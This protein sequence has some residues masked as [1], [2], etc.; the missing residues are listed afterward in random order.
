MAQ[1]AETNIVPV[2]DQAMLRS[3]VSEAATSRVPVVI[4]FENDITLTGTALTILRDANVTLTSD[5]ALASASGVEFFRLL[6]VVGANTILVDGGGILKLDGIIVTHASGNGRGVEVSFS[7][8]LELCSGVISGNTLSGNGAGVLN[9]GTFRMYGGMIS[10]N[11]AN[12]GGGVYNSDGTFILDAGVISNN[13]ASSYGAGVYSTGI[14]SMRGGEISSNTITHYYSGGGVYNS[15]NFVLESGAI[16]RNYAVL[17][18]GVCSTSAFTMSGG[19]ISDNTVYSDGGG[20]YSIGSSLK[21][22]GG[23]I[24][25]NTAPRN[26]GGV[27]SSGGLF[28]LSACVI[29][30]NTAVN[31]GGVWR[32]GV[33]SMSN[34]VVSDNHVSGNGG[35]VYKQDSGSVFSMYG[36]KISGNTADGTGGGGVYINNGNFEMFDGGVISN[37]RAPIGGGICLSNGLVHLYSGKIS[38]NYANIGGGI[39]VTNTYG[40]TLGRLTVEADVDFSDNR[41]NRGYNRQPAD[42]TGYYDRI[43]CVV[44]SDPFEQGYNNY[45]ISYVRGSPLTDFTVHVINGSTKWLTYISDGPTCATVTITAD[46][47]P[48]GQSFTEWKVISG[49]VHIVNLTNSVTTFC[50][51]A[52]P[53]VIE[54][55][56]GADFIPIE[57]HPIDQT[58]TQ[59]SITGS[60]SIVV[61]PSTSVVYQYQ[62]Y[63]SIIASNSSGTPINGAT[64]SQ[65]A[66]PTDLTAANSPYY[67]YCMVSAP[68][69]Q[70]TASNIANVT[71][72]LPPSP[73]L[74]DIKATAYPSKIVYI[75]GEVLDLSGLVVTVT[76]SDNSS[77]TT[78]GYTTIPA[79]GTALFNIG[80]QNVTISYTEGGVTKETRFPIT[81]ESIVKLESI[82]VTAQPGKIVY[83]VGETLN[84]AGMVVTAKFTNENTEPIIGYIA[85]PANGTTLNNPGTQT[86]LVS[87]T[88]GG[89]TKN[90]TFNITVN[91]PLIRLE[92]IEVTSEPNKTKYAEGEALDLSG[93]IITATYSNN[94]SKTVTDYIINPT[95]DTILTTVGNVTVNVSYTENGETKTTSFTVSVEKMGVTHILDSIIVSTYPTNRNYTV[96]EVLDLSGMVIIAKYSNGETADVTALVATDPVNG[97]AL[98][99][100]GTQRV[101]VSYNEYNITRQDHFNVTVNAKPSMLVGIN[102]T[103]PSKLVYTVGEVLDLTGLV[104]T[105][106][107]SDGSPKVVT[108]YTITPLNGTVLP[109]VGTQNITISYTETGV[110]VTD[111]FEITI[112]P[113]IIPTDIKITMLPSK[114]VYTKGT[115]LDLAGLVVTVTY[116]DGSSKPV[117]NYTTVPANGTTLD[118]IGMMVIGVNYTEAGVPMTA[119][120]EV[121]VIYDPI[122]DPIDAYNQVYAEFSSYYN[123][124]TWQFHRDLFTGYTIASVLKAESIMNDA[125]QVHAYLLAAYGKLDAGRFS[126]EDKEEALKVA[127]HILTQAIANMHLA[128]EPLNPPELF[129][130]TSDMGGVIRVWLSYPVEVKNIVAVMD[131]QVIEFDDAILRGAV[132]WVPGIGYIDAL[133]HVDVFKVGNWQSMVLTLTAYGQVFVFE[134]KNDHYVPP[135]E[136]VITIIEPTCTLEGYTEHC[137]LPTGEKWFSDYVPALGH[138]F[139]VL[140]SEGDYLRVMCLV[141]GWEGYIDGPGQIAGRV[142]A[143]DANN[144]VTALVGS[145]QIQLFAESN[146]SA[147]LQTTFSDAWGYYSFENVATGQYAIEFFVEGYALLQ[148]FNVHVE[149]GKTTYIDRVELIQTG[150]ANGTIS[151]RIINAMTNQAV[152]DKLTLDFCNGLN[153][154]SENTNIIT[155]ITT[156]SNGQYSI[157]LPA[158][159][160]TLT[161]HGEN[162]LTATYTVHSYSGH[163]VNFDGYVLSFDADLEPVLFNAHWYVVF[164]IGMTWHQ[165]KALCEQLG[166]HLATVTSQEESD[167]IYHL[168]QNHDKEHYYLGG[169]DEDT[170]HQWRWITGESWEFT[171]WAPGEPNNIGGYESY[172]MVYRTGDTQAGKWND[173]VYNV[174]VVLG[175]TGFIC[176]WDQ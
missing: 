70:N 137:Y 45:D 104:V 108:D 116:N 36:G 48:E 1:G 87:Y 105:A 63:S 158:G 126:A 162:Y 72:L 31:G 166:G 152:S 21:L 120:F 159:S 121:S 149:D 106:I 107:Y 15:G 82:L 135:V 144:V 33:F 9:S 74:T 25:G 56:F 169:T 69:Y 103:L 100:V 6:G 140:Y 38:D 156:N 143:V 26:G 30:G 64:L 168:I 101:T 91:L 22:S 95:S 32:S 147:V 164:D 94:S 78:M 173:T 97:T 23:V 8:I 39:W 160:Y 46:I 3:A 18:G 47:P 14:F 65:F 172:L 127:T 5:S 52:S 132:A 59:G 4:V 75:E 41:A 138:D 10:G 110:T 150:T 44:W 24:S 131:G 77:K 58:V 98:I 171:N 29:S 163:T 142:A 128:L 84:L 123:T 86:I 40:A 83:T 68:G 13:K 62:W 43:K 157:S 136:W 17:G 93:L 76:Y 37:N 54:A 170:R 102:V 50:M 57:R 96:G 118:T 88:T 139:E 90:D 111:R 129:A 42:D 175:S 119:N 49:D 35:G 51:P 161:A 85:T 167:F 81:V 73:V 151:G 16:I 153:N 7:G 71:V 89:I 134:L 109:I 28:D 122:V 61:M 34:A 2:R 20:V 154:T 176:E 11:T 80:M 145:A 79:N 117:I 148:L 99:T 124:T 174:H 130:D 141:C 146:T 19:V 133:S 12:S 125:G 92:R 113:Q 115:T 66:I 155:S 114:V 112:N 53:V 60:L 67:Y 55:H 27:Y 165:A